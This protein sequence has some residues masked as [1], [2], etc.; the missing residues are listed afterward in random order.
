MICLLG[1]HRLQYAEVKQMNQRIR[2]NRKISEEMSRG[3][4]FIREEERCE[5]G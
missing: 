4:G 2:D 5:N 1:D 3:M